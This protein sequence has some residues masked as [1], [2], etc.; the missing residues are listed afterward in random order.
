MQAQQIRSTVTSNVRIY[1][2]KGCAI[3]LCG[4]PRATS[5]TQPEKFK[6]VHTPAARVSFSRFG[7][8]SHL[9]RAR[10]TAFASWNGWNET[11]RRI[12]EEEGDE[13]TQM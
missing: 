12:V 1:E 9:F 7:G 11:K 10:S 13:K 4:V 3:S 8:A 6:N 2:G 5:L